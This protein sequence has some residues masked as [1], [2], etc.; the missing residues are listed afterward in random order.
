VIVGVTDTTAETQARGKQ[1]P[2]PH[3]IWYTPVSGIW[4]TVWIEPVP[5][6]YIRHI[7]IQADD[8][9]VALVVD[10]SDRAAMKEGKIEVLDGEKVIARTFNPLEPTDFTLSNPKLWSPDSP[11]LYRLRV[12]AGEDVIESYFGMR[13]I[14][15]AADEKG[16]PRIKLNGKDI[17]Q[18]GPLDQGWWPDGLY[19]APSDEALIYDLECYE[20]LGFNMIRKL[21]RGRAAALVLRGPTRPACLVWSGHALEARC[22]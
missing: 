4:Q 17:M 10:G 3:G 21:V 8:K 16:I 1:I 15:V 5:K 6:Q 19:T 9:K 12:T 2:D 14:E 7:N 18:V 22:R 20:K 11:F 13:K